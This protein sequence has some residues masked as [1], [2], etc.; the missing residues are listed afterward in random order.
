MQAGR[1]KRKIWPFFILE[2]AGASLPL[3]SLFQ[4]NSNESDVR[5]VLLL[6]QTQ[7]LLL[8]IM[9]GM[10]NSDGLRHALQLKPPSPS[11]KLLIRLP[12]DRKEKICAETSYKFNFA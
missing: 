3:A 2:M 10:S 12:M 5:F 6:K 1:R 11:E 9:A 4:P 8:W 7:C